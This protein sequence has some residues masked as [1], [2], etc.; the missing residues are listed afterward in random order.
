MSMLKE[1]VKNRNLYTMAIPGLVFLVVFS[2]I[3]LAGHLLAFKDFQISKG[4][5]GSDWV[6]LD[7]FR[8]FFL[9]SGLDP[10]Y[11]QYVVFEC[12]VH[13]LRDGLCNAHRALLE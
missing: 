13:Y 1:L 12:V 10:S 7:N 8:F 3:P 11:G 5:W 2:Y 9:Q 4:I 6:G